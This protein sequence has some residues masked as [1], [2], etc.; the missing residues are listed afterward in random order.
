MCG[1]LPALPFK[2]DRFD[3]A[4]SSHFL[5]LYADHF[6]EAFHLEAIRALLVFAREVRIFPLIALRAERSQHL[7]PVCRQ[8][9]QEDYQV[10]IERVGYGSSEGA[11]T[12]GFNGHECAEPVSDD[13]QSGYTFDRPAETTLQASAHEGPAHATQLLVKHRRVTGIPD[14]P[15]A[16]AMIAVG[17]PGDPA[18]LDEKLRGVSWPLVS[19]SLSARSSPPD[20][21]TCRRIGCP[22]DTGSAHSCPLNAQHFIAPSLELIPYPFDRHLVTLLAQLATDRVQVLRPFGSQCNQRKDPDLARDN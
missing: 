1:S 3:L 17:Y 11:M 7:N 16:S 21:G 4:L 10:S 9:R 2:P 19:G 12:C 20:D 8:F 5:F 18:M 14:A 22:S 6:S 13:N 15:F